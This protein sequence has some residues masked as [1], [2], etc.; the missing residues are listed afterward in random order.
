MVFNNRDGIGRFGMGMKT[1]GLSMAPAMEIMSWQERGAIYRTILDTDAIGRDKSNLLTVGEP[2]YLETLDVD[3]ANIFT[4][5]MS[6]PRD[7]KEQEIFAPYGVDLK[8]ALGNSG[9]IVYMPD[10]DRLT[11]ATAKTLVED[12][13]KT[14]GHVYR[15]KII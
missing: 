9:T 11:S 7:A 4:T 10:C 1:A 13:T 12:A 15:R 6:F 5:P 2:E 8:E 14:F 3:V